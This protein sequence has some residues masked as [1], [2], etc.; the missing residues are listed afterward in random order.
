MRKR[1][2]IETSIPSF[3]YEARMEPDMIARRDWTRQWW[4]MLDQYEVFT[5]GAVRYELQRGEYPGKEEALLLLSDIPD[6]EVV[7]IIEDIVKA[8]VQH[9]L[10][11]VN[12]LGDAMHLAYHGCD[13][14]L[15]WN[16]RNIAN[17]N[18]FTHIR[19]IN[20]M[21]GLSIPELVTPYQLLEENQ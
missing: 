3:F 10:M 17:P 4:S 8:Y 11:P 7:D 13:Y 16:C 14:L 12:P 18:K 15:T 2:Y 21:L 5:S 6:L 9:H 20:T 1:V 19:I